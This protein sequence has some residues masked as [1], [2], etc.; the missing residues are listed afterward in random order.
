MVPTGRQPLWHR[1]KGTFQIE[2]IFSASNTCMLA[3][4]SLLK[5]WEEELVSPQLNTL[6]QSPNKTLHG[7]RCLERIITLMENSTVMLAWF[8]RFLMT[9]QYI[10]ILL[11]ASGIHVEYVELLWTNPLSASVVLDLNVILLLTCNYISGFISLLMILIQISYKQFKNTT[12]STHRG[13]NGT[14]RN[15]KQTVQLLHVWT[16]CSRG[17]SWRVFISRAAIIFPT[18]PWQSWKQTDDILN[19]SNGQV[20]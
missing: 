3:G 1:F 11:D 16:T 7:E 20:Q 18:P 5:E 8:G 10:L 6:L 4:W 9:P 12:V 14:S 15:P 2:T 17:S 13:W 19:P